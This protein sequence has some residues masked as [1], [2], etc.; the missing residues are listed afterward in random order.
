MAFIQRELANLRNQL[1]LWLPSY[2]YSV[3]EYDPNS[4]NARVSEILVRL[5]QQDKDSERREGILKAILDEQRKTNG[6]VSALE[7][8]VATF[9]AKAA[10]IVAIGSAVASA[11]WWWVK[12]KVLK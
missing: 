12:E 7:L 10:V 9:K 8:F 5:E 3:S 11:V 4:L 6:R 2:L 1:G